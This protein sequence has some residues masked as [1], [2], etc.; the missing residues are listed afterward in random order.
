ML[1]IKEISKMK[2]YTLSDLANKLGIGRSAFHQQINGNP[3]LET[4]E[5][6]ASALNVEIWELFT[7]SIR[8]DE[9]TALVDHRGRLYKANSIEELQGIIEEIKKEPV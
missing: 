4:L 8:K 6:I 7:P 1:R 3:T 2:G 9:L 5:K